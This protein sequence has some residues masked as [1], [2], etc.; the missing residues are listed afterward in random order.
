MMKT[1]S[2]ENMIDIENTSLEDVSLSRGTSRSS[3]QDN[4]LVTNKTNTNTNS[5]KVKTYTFV[6][7]LGLFIILGFIAWIF[8]IIYN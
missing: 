2:C 8:Y 4:L 3:Y 7:A 5:K 1:I 6:L